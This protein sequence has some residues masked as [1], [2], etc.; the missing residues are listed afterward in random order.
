MVTK[1]LRTKSYLRPQHENAAKG[2]SQA[3]AS[4]V[5]WGSWCKRLW[6]GNRLVGSY[7]S[8]SGPFRDPRS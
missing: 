8:S 3:Q 1:T 7:G 4:V 5:P 6:E 2:L